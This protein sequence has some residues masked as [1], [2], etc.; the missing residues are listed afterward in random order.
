MMRSVELFVGAGGLGM[1]AA[2]AGFESAAA[3]D[4]DRWACDTIRENQ[5]RGFPLVKDWPLHECDVRDFDYS[6]IGAEIDIMIGG[7]P[8]QPFSI[9]GKHRGYRDKRDMLATMVN[10][11]RELRPRA[12][13]VENV[14]GLTRPKLANYFEYITLQL[15]FP[16]E[17]RRDDEDWTEHV[18]KLER[19]KTT[20]RHRG[21]EYEVVWRVINAADHGVPQRRERVFIVGF[22][23]DQ[24]AKWTF[25]NPTHSLDALL[26]DQWIAGEYWERHGVPRRE[27]P[28][29]ENG[30]RS[31]VERLRQWNM[32]E[33]RPWR[34]VRDAI[35]D[36]PPPGP[37]SRSGKFMNHRFQ[38]GARP[39][40]GHT[41][42]P[43]DMPAKTLKAGDHGVPG[44]ENTLRRPSGELRYFTVR[45]AARLQTFPDGYMF[46]GSWTETMRQ[47]GNAVP[48][49]LAQRIAASVATKLAEASARRMSGR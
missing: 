2:L 4:L 6:S 22:R 49:A 3:I 24:D 7:P 12:F 13:I 48:V 21:L 19:H 39:Y 32:W 30:A 20:G 33:M 42:S 38:P 47:L 16:E 34:T 31:R 43:L 23:A 15:A 40:K 45:E 28:A 11:V 10:A 5:A 18:K 35:S 26:F 44:G 25:P 17:R 36:L 1:G 29:L 8:C 14:R 46:H 41:G 27:R 9:A 37:D